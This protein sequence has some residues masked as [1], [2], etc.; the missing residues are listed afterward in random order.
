MYAIDSSSLFLLPNKC[1]R[2]K[3]KMC[4][5]KSRE[6]NLRGSCMGQILDYPRF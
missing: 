2:K 3:K 1:N 5:N 6:A 4:Y